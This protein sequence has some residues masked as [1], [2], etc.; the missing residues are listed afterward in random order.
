MALN[1]PVYNADDISFGPAVIYIGAAGAT[2]TEDFGAIADDGLNMEFATEVRDIMQGNP[3]VSI[4]SFIQSQEITIRMTSIEWN[5]DRF[6]FA[7][8]AGETTAGATLETFTF[9]GAPCP[10]E[11][12]IEFHHA[13]CR[14]GDTIVGKIWRAQG[15][16]SLAIPFGN[17]EHSFEFNFKAMAA[18]TDWAGTTLGT[19]EQLLRFE[20]QLAAT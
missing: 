17:D 18:Q 20:R 7:L 9:G 4:L 15:Q 3:K 1:V 13:M 16:G 14:T 6:T 5:F 2:P 11:A 19:E 8:G 10:R 12:A